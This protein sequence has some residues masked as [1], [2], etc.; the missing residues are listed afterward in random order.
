MN[1]KYIILEIIPTKIDKG[2]IVQLS[3]L[4]VK[5]L[6]IVD[7]FDYRLSKEKVN[8]LDLLMM[9]SY[10]ED[11]FK[12]VNSTKKIKIDFK[13][14]VEDYEL[15][16]MDNLYTKNYIKYI[17]NKKEDIFKLLNVEFSDDVISIIKEKYNLED[18]N[19]I[20]DLLYEAL[21]FESNR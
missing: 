3:A 4:K 12:Y 16:I 7:R 11:N 13:K 9:T 17:N 14:W 1:K 5:D 19:H 18:S 2:E 20:V 21:I 10:D 15:L 6:K 8:N